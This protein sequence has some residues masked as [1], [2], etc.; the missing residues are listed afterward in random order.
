MYSGLSRKEFGE[1]FN[2]K[3]C[4]VYQWECGRCIPMLSKLLE[5]SQYFNVSIDSIIKGKTPSETMLEKQL[6]NLSTQK[7]QFSMYDSSDTNR[8]IAQ[9]N[10]LPDTHKERLLGYLDALSKD[11]G[12]L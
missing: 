9:F 4:T 10:S 6:N 2:S 3:D 7:E 8:F 11:S 5:I 1:Q 12:I